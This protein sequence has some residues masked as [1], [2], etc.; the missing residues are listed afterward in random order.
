MSAAFA[1]LNAGQYALTVLADGFGTVTNTPR[2]SRFNS[3]ASVTL[4]ALP[5]A[6]QQFL[7]WSGDASGTNN[8]LTMAMTASKVITA[9]FTRRPMLALQPCSEP[10]PGDGFQFLLL[11]ESGARYQVEKNDD[12]QGWLPLATVTNIF[13]TTQFNDVSA[14][15][16]ARRAYRAVVGP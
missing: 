6:G 5:D 16:Q 11:G 10:S 3:G 14:T 15:N 9:Q 2:G 12:W 8:P 13:G 7:S 4:T 1:A